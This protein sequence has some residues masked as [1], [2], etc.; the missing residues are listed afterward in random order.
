MKIQ[1][2]TVTGNFL[3]KIQ[4]LPRE[5]QKEIIFS[6]PFSMPPYIMLSLERLDEGQFIEKSYFSNEKNERIMHTVN[7]YDISAQNISNTGFILNIKTWSQNLIYGY[8]ITWLAI[9]DSYEK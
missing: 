5:D 2:G 3:P 9:G 6:S 7:R 1:Q 8:R 4:N